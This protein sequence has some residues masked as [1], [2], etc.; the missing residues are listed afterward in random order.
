MQADTSTPIFE[1]A[2]PLVVLPVIATKYFPGIAKQSGVTNA[3]M[4]FELLGKRLYSFGPGTTQ[5]LS[6]DDDMITAWALSVGL[7]A[8]NFTRV[9][10]HMQLAMFVLSGSIVKADAKFKSRPNRKIVAIILFACIKT[11]VI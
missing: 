7:V 8:V 2:D 1:V 3:V 5:G 9:V 6:P 11:F 10:S 4:L